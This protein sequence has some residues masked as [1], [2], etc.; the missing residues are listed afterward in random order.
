MDYSTALAIS[1]VSAA[2]KI[3]AA[4][5]IGATVIRWWQAFIKTKSY[6]KRKH[7]A[8]VERRKLAAQEKA[9]LKLAK[10]KLSGAAEAHHEAMLEKKEAAA[11][12]VEKQKE[13]AA[14]NLASEQ[15][16]L[17]AQRIRSEQRAALKLASWPAAKMEAYAAAMQMA[18]GGGGGAEAA[19]AATVGK[20]KSKGKE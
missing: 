9:N 4:N 20:G 10:A 14:A 5:V 17:T 13:K 6:K 8:E 12:D 15:K 1:T 16:R 11:V 3:I 19:P 2:S 7:A 18:A